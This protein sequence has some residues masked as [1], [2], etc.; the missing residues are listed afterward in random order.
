MQPIVP[1]H[2][3]SPSRMRYRFERLWLKK[4]VRQGVQFWI[5]VALGSWVVFA[6][7]GNATVQATMDNG[8]TGLRDTVAERPQ[9]QV[10][11]LSMPDAS[12]DLQ[13]QIFAVTGV[14]LPISALDIDVAQIKAAVEKLDSVETATVMVH[15]DGLL[16][17]RTVERVP[18]IVW[19]DGDTL[20]LI[21]NDGNRVA[22]L[23]RRSARGDL[24]LI[25]GVGAENN[26]P[27][28]MALMAVIAPVGNRLRGFV[29][30]GE[31]RWDVVLDR[32]QTIMLPE[33]GAV[34]ALRRVMALHQIEDLLTRDVVVVDMRNG[35]RPVLRLTDEAISELRRLRAEV[36]GTD[37]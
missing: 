14:S 16:E 18:T 6:T 23:A 10:T 31:R 8:L 32:G 36:R 37:A 35:A 1:R 2:D 7:L 13:A 22:V 15:S 4:S 27:E 11:M 17:I 21:D 33:A 26:V 12:V 25:V 28:V 24:P 29:R 3:P 19:R 30:V 5:P 20:R 9:L 34:T